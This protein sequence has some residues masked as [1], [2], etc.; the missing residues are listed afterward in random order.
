MAALPADPEVAFVLGIVFRQLG[1]FFAIAGNGKRYFGRIEPAHESTVPQL[2]G[3]KPHQ[4]LGSPEQWEGAMRVV[5]TLLSALHP[6]DKTMLFDLFA[7]CATD[8]RGDFRQQ[9]SG[10]GQ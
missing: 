7:D 5:E 3:S 10:L 8:P 2:P 9:L 1:G 6:D 4:R